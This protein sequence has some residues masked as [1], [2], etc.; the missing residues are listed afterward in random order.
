MNSLSLL[1][2]LSALLVNLVFA[3][4]SPQLQERW[5]VRH[6]KI[7]SMYAFE[8]FVYALDVGLL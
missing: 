3:H 6:D 5:S 7:T 4:P 8:G 1:A 2:T